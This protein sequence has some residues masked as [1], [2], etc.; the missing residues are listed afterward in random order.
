MKTGVCSPNSKMCGPYDKTT[1]GGA[2]QNR[3]DLRLAFAE[4]INTFDAGTFKSR[5]G[6]QDFAFDLQ[7]FISSRDGPNVRQSLMRC[8]PTG[9][10]VSG[11][12][13]ASPASRCSIRTGGT[14]TTHP[15]A[16]RAFI[17]CGS[18]DW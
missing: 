5:I 2:D 13:S 16:M 18:S 12:L 6:R 8:G 17:C 10:P 11:A 7:R 9:R 15:T 3:V 4:Y 1:I 14:S